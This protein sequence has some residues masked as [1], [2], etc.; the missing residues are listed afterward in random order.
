MTKCREC[1]EH[2]FCIHTCIKERKERINEG[3]KKGKKKERGPRGKKERPIRFPFY[4]A[5]KDGQAR[6]HGSEQAIELSC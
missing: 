1:Y 5:L 3:R 2:S 4:G 6:T